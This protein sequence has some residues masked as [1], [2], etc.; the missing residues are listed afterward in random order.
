M[1]FI[2]DSLSE[3]DLVHFLR[4]PRIPVKS[5]AVTEYIRPPPLVKLQG[6]GCGYDKAITGGRKVQQPD[7]GEKDRVPDARTVWM[8]GTSLRT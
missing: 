8:Y 7:S 5:Q 6:G 4:Y 3:T 2:A 1:F